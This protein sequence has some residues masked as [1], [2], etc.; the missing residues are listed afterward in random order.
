MIEI[1]TVFPKHPSVQKLADNELNL[2]NLL[3]FCSKI[4]TQIQTHLVLIFK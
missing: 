1:N 3:N 2:L 4:L